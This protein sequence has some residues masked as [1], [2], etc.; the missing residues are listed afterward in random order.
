M[1]KD[2]KKETHLIKKVN[3]PKLEIIENITIDTDFMSKLLENIYKNSNKFEK[4]LKQSESRN[5]FLGTYELLK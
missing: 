2:Q 3:R 1:L 5:S 4:K